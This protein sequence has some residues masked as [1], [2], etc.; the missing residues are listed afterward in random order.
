MLYCTYFIG[1]NEDTSTA[2]YH[3]FTVL[4]YLFPLFGGALADGYLGKFK[5][6]FYLSIVYVI[7]MGIQAVAAIPFQDS[8]VSFR[9]PNA[10]LCIAGLIVI[11]I[12]TGGIKPCV[13]SFG[14][15]Q[16]ESDD[17]KNTTLF[18]D[19]FYW[20]INAGSV[21]STFITPLLRQTTCGSLGTEDSCYFLSFAIPA[22][23]MCVAIALFLLG[24]RYYIKVPPSGRN[25]FWEV[26]KCIFLGA[27]RKIPA[28][29]P[30]QDHWLYGAYGSVDDWIIRDTTY[31]VKVL[32]MF[33]P[34]PIF[35][36]AF[37]QKGSRW[38][39]QALRMNGYLSETVYVL[40]DQVQLLNAGFIL[41]FIPIFNT[42]YKLID[43]CFGAGTVTKLRKI[44]VGLIFGALAYV[45]SAEVQKMIDVNLTKSPEIASEIALS[46]INL[47]SQ[48][49]SGHFASAD[50]ELDERL[51]ATYEIMPGQ[52]AYNFEAEIPAQE[53]ITE[54]Q[55]GD[56]YQF[57]E[58]S[59]KSYTTFLQQGKIVS[60][61]ALMEYAGKK[62][63]VNYIGPT[64]K[65]SDGN[66]FITAINGLTFN[67]GW[68]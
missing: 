35:W 16:F 57:V 49:V 51:Q 55:N 34:L 1:F 59:S 48:P 41:L 61:L 65:D 60:N 31:L 18:F 27:F 11:A 28:D 58:D 38:T 66:S 68:L 52:K 13:S 36:A 12:G 7:G 62:F 14:G 54:W 64:K 4:A 33:S 50:V 47:Q 45:V 2:I 44:S 32:V 6:I 9:T 56:T 67:T 15:D 3:G 37:D 8:S 19:M 21:I 63:S 22:T 30:V 5:T 29:S 42:A 43:K 46:A 20:C 17:V 40:A 39:L 53:I 25:I 26:L 10:I 23:L 24:N